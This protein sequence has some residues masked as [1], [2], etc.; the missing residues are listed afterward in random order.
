M[1][2]GP[3][4]W[5]LKEVAGERLH[6]KWEKACINKIVWTRV[7]PSIEM[8]TFADFFSSFGSCVAARGF[9]QGIALDNSIQL[10]MHTRCLRKYSKSQD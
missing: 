7:Q 3:C 5:Q 9:K 6:G 1:W 4:A 10:C 2:H 8:V